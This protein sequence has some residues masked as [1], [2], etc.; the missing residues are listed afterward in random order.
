MRNLE[1]GH[2][3]MESLLLDIDFRSVC[4]D[5]YCQSLRAEET[6]SSLATDG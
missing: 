3:A 1:G 2:E 6:L 5:V 4:S